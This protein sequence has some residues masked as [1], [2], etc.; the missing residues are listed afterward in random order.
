MS[1]KS[2]IQGRAYEFICLLTLQEE[3]NKIRPARIVTN[4]SY[5]AAQRAWNKLTTNIQNIYKT[6]AYAAVAKIFTLEPRIIEKGEDVLELLIQTDK[7]GE[8]GDVRDI[9]IIRNRIHWEIGL[10]LKHNHFAVKH[11]RLSD[12]LDFGSKWYGIPCSPDY[13]K[14]IHSAFDYL[15]ACQKRHLKFKELP[16]KEKDVYIPLLKA[17]INEI[18][19][20]YAEHK[21]IPGKL[22]KYLLGEYD[23]YKIISIDKERNTKIQSYNL[24]G[25]LGSASQTQ[26]PAKII[27]I[28]SLPTRIVNLDF[29]PG[30]QNTVELYMD[31]GWQFSFRIHNAKNDVEPSLK[32]DIQIIGMPITIITLNCFWN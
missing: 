15:K 25:T 22:V 17:F 20:Q 19:R 27:P 23:F 7:K 8:S 24:H 9:L 3:T 29:V 16:N 5:Y 14:E 4:S 11:S 28:V 1:D 10:S 30:S 21:N 32:F 13:W 2:N 12:R 6:S 18:K 31:E 26:K